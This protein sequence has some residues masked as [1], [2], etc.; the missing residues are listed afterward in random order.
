[1]WIEIINLNVERPKISKVK[2]CLNIYHLMFCKIIVFM[3]YCIVR[4]CNGN[5][6]LPIQ[7]PGSIGL[8][9]TFLEM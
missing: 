4:N 7:F 3:Q 6:V 2:D 9:I 8:G 5:K 1:M